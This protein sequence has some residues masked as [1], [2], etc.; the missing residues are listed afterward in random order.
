VSF[1][2][3][4]ERILQNEILVSNIRQASG[5]LSQAR[6]DVSNNIT[7]SGQTE[8]REKFKAEYRAKDGI[9]LGLGENYLLTILL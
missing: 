8:F 5:D 4:P 7:K 1:V 2:R 9:T 6:E 3:W